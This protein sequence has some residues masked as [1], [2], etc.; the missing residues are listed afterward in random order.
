MH[1]IY[2]SLLYY[3]HEFLADRFVYDSE[4]GLHNKL[5]FIIG[6]Y[7]KNNYGA[8]FSI[9]ARFMSPE[10]IRDNVLDYGADV[11]AFGCTVLEMLTGERV[12]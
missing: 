6:K 11:W 9:T 8:T 3:N 7:L 4:F 10:L 2:I 5:F 12:W 1:I